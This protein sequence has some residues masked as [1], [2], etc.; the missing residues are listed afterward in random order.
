MITKT[1]KVPIIYHKNIQSFFNKIY[2]NQKLIKLNEETA[3]ANQISNTIQKI[4]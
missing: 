4:N 3:T 1:A 2:E